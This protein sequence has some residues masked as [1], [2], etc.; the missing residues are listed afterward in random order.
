M[1]CPLLLN[2]HLLIG[3]SA[4][5][6]HLFSPLR[7]SVSLSLLLRAQGSFFPLPSFSLWYF[8]LTN[9]AQT[10]FFPPSPSLS[11]KRSTDEIKELLCRP[12]ER[13]QRSAF[14]CQHLCPDSF[15]FL[16]RTDYSLKPR[17]F[18]EDEESFNHAAKH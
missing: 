18:G 9:Q 12:H 14:Q 17:G 5:V 8:P 16:G 7:K 6:Q 1:W 3:I 13:S 11:C 4:V 15:G 10:C 2:F